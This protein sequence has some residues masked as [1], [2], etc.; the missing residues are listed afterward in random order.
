MTKRSKF[1][2]RTKFSLRRRLI[3]SAIILGLSVWSVGLV[4]FVMSVSAT[5]LIL[6]EK[7]DAIIVLTGGAKRLVAG[8]S[9]LLEGQ[10]N[11]LLVSGVNDKVTRSDLRRLFIKWGKSE[12][13]K[14]LN[15]CISLGYSAED[16]RGNAKE[17]WNWIRDRGFNSIFLVTSN[18][19]MRRSYLEFKSL[20]PHIRII[21]YPVIAN[22]LN[23]EDSLVRPRHLKLVLSEYNKFVL[24]SLRSYF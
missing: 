21:K 9:L 18:Y 19:H 23:K 13:A 17:S 15:C 24:V 2:G 1:I 7:A 22:T 3:I 6:K 11:S 10:A 12:G 16:T 14:F 4:K 20:M 5:E 8:V